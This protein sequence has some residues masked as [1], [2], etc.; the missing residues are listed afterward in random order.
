[1]NNENGVYYDFSEFDEFE[2]DKIANKI[3]NIVAEMRERYGSS[4]ILVSTLDN[5]KI[6]HHHVFIIM[7]LET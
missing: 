6:A 2:A 4:V 5:E 1:M 7:C 3:T